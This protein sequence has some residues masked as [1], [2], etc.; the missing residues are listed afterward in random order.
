MNS[1]RNVLWS[2]H[3]RTMAITVSLVSALSGCSDDGPD[4]EYAIPATLCGTVIDSDDLA[5]FLPAGREI[6]VKDDFRSGIKDC[7][8]IIDN[9]LVLTT[10][11]AWLENGRTTAYFASGQTLDTPSHSA[12]GGRFRYS[13]KEAFGKTRH[14]VDAEYGQELYTA[15]QAQG[16]RHEDADAMKRL[17]TSYTAEVEKSAECAA[18]A[19]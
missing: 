15:V 1:Q 3:L 2:H 4:R 7:E 16:S 13:G 6:S 17:I 11:Q 9:V 10:T 18:G 14:C 5:P 19:Q 12:Q 8:V